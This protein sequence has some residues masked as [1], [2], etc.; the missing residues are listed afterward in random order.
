[1]NPAHADGQR[2]GIL[3]PTYNRPDL[4][5]AA[6]LQLLAQSRRP[7]IVCIHQNGH[8]DSYAWAVRDIRSSAR[9]EWLHT[10]GRIAQHQWYA[11]PLRFLLAQGCTRFF[12]TDHDDLYLH[13]HV[14]AGLADLREH[15]FSVSRRSGLLFTRG[16]DWRYGADV[17]FTSHAPGGMSST[18]CFNREFA[19]QL[20]ADLEADTQHQYSDN[21]VAHVTMPRFR[22]KVSQRR[23]CVYHS[24]EG[25][26]TSAGWLDKAFEQAGG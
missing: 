12:W 16:A 4:A 17:E 2:V 5:R 20:L 25:S 26:V 23:T 19:Q 21:V 14:A 6:V 22:C 8:P 1:M 10:P 7:D 15:D 9:L 3:L 24:H 18:M 11:I 13:D